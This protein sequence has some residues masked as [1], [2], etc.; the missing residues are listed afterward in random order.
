MKATWCVSMA[1][2][3]ELLRQ[4]AA[5]LTRLNHCMA[6]VRRANSVFLEV[7][8]SYRH[9]TT[10]KQYHVVQEF[11]ATGEP[12]RFARELRLLPMLEETMLRALQEGRAE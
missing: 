6:D 2:R 12:K 7:R 8:L 1:D 11:E 3:L 5:K 4:E 9:P 10:H